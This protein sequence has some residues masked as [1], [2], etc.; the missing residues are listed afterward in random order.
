MEIEHDDIAKV[1]RVNVQIPVTQIEEEC[2]N[3]F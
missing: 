3:N 1:E 2:Y